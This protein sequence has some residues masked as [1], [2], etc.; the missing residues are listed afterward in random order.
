MAPL[1]YRFLKVKPSETVWS[2][3]QPPRSTH[4]HLNNQTPFPSF[5]RKFLSRLGKTPVVLPQITCS[6]S[7]DQQI[8]SNFCR[9]NLLW[10]LWTV[11][12]QSHKPDKGKNS[13][14]V[15]VSSSPGPAHCT[16]NVSIYPEYVLMCVNQSTCLCCSW[17]ALYSRQ[18]M[19]SFRPDKLEGNSVPTWKIQYREI[20]Q[21]F[22]GL[23]AVPSI[24]P[25]DVCR[26]WTF[27]YPG[28]TECVPTLATYPP[29]TR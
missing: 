3:R 23:T 8:A 12:D 9:V 25:Y 4:K 10:Y 17:P 13:I 11:S 16:H 2:T 21:T 22:L 7:P 28:Y 24:N 1:K 26:C 27:S 18:S 29:D 5:L 14:H 20:K 6:S 15:L 19:C